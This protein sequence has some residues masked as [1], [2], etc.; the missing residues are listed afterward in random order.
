MPLAF[1]TQ[2]V[3]HTTLCLGHNT[4]FFTIVICQMRLWKVGI[5]AT[6]WSEAWPQHK[7]NPNKNSHQS[8]SSQPD[9]GLVVGG[10]PEQAHVSHGC[11]R[12]HHTKSSHEAKKVEQRSWPARRSAFCSL[13]DSQRMSATCLSGPNQAGFAFSNSLLIRKHCKIRLPLLVRM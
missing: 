1:C 11:R 8:P 7:F 3:T 2:T 10:K 6:A 4:Q 13:N 9:A 5:L 12:T